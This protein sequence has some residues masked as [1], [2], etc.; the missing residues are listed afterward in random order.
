MPDRKAK[1]IL[2]AED[3]TKLALKSAERNFSTFGKQLNGV[4]GGLQLFGPLA[5]VAAVAGFARFVDGAIDSADALAKTADKIGIT[6]DLLQELN[7]AAERSGIS[8]GALAGNMTAF[9]KRVGEARQATGPLVGFLKK[10]DETL[11]DAIKNSKNQE[12]AL[13]LIAEAIKNA[14]T[15][16]DRAAIANAA[17]SRSGIDMVN[18]LKD[19]KKGLG[20]FQRAAH[21]AGLVIEES[22]LRTAEDVNDAWDTAIETLSFKFKRSV[23]EVVRGTNDLLTSAEDASLDQLGRKKASAANRYLITLQSAAGVKDHPAVQ[24]I[25]DEINAIDD[26]IIA[27]NKEI[28]VREEVEKKKGQS[29][30]GRGGAGDDGGSLGKGGPDPFDALLQN[31]QRQLAL[32]DA[33]TQ[34]ERV[35]WE[36]Q[37]GRYKDLSE[38]QQKALLDSARAIDNRKAEIQIEKGRVN[39]Q[40]EALEA[41]ADRQEELQR[42]EDE[43]RADAGQK[44]AEDK[45]RLQQQAQYWRELVNPMLVYDQQIEELD[46]LL[47]ESAIT[48][49]TYSDALNKAAE[50]MQAEG[51]AM[52]EF[53]I[54]AAHSI[55][56]TISGGIF[57]VMQGELDG[58]GLKFKRVVDRMVADA[59][60]AELGKKLLGDYGGTGNVGGWIGAIAS[61]F[62]DGGIAGQ[63][64]SKRFLSVSPAAIANAPR[65]HTE[66]IAGLKPRDELAVLQ[67]GEE[68]LREDNPRHINNAGGGGG[69]RIINV[70][71]PAMAGDYLESAAGERTILNILGRNSGAVKEVLA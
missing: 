12:E 51:E 57:D 18:M 6:T 42:L 54:Q 1:Y 41:A 35:L 56:S 43:R 40:R 15:A 27:K 68:I 61:V 14:S 60:A 63:G 52:N 69:T 17:F 45:A 55:Q 48:W 62:H 13:E 20:E 7:F 2:E 4:M 19:G 29:G 26:L 16:T 11:L 67:K 44:V 64:N 32:I 31:S 33:T 49:E 9:V 50:N 25:V 58:I 71:D 22:L 5:G 66:G 38:Q 30:K 28:A 59:I 21:D 70:M 8:T 53:A 37:N 24:R 10:Y 39:A 36:V 65:Y 3:R 34:Y 23:L 47:L 46:N